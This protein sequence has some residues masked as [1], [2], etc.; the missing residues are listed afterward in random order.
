MPDSRTHR[1]PD[2]RDA[3]AFGPETRAA[4]REAVADFSWL[5]GR[6]Y[7][8]ASALKLVGDRWS[9]TERQ[10][11]A[12]R[13]SACPDTLLALRLRHRMGSPDLCGQPLAVDGFNVLTTVEAALGGAVVLA[14]R[15]GSYRDLMGVHGTY[16][17]VEE[18]VPAIRLV[19]E[20]LAALGAGPFLWLL[21]SP[22]SNSGRLCGLLRDAA[23]EFG[24]DWQVEL[25]M[26]PDPLLADSSHV[27]ATAD[28]AILDRCSRWFPLRTP[29]SNREFPMPI[30]LTSRFQTPRDGCPILGQVRQLR[31]Q[32]PRGTLVP[33]P[34]LDSLS[35][36]FLMNNG[37]GPVP[38][39]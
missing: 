34:I 28:G 22:V 2:P 20:V 33:S 12:V 36:I 38:G 11:M 30:S 32:S 6:D 9:L 31:R 15:D 21:D 10:R 14:G 27:I 24:W 8:L 39:K 17:K 26:N 3:D 37:D 16:R 25:V 13:R 18:T 35:S 4:L 7:S 1:G 5:L 29:W 19:G 23:H